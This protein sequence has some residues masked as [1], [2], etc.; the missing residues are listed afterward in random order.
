ML[1]K[2]TERQPGPSES[3]PPKKTPAAAASPETEPQTPSALLRSVPSA[4]VVVRIESAAG[5][6]IAAPTPC[7]RRALISNPALVARPP[8]SDDRAKRNKPATR[9]RR[10]PSRSAARPPRSKKPP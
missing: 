4:K 2:S 3:T 6:I 5:A 1:T 10:R 7:I 8:V 9:I